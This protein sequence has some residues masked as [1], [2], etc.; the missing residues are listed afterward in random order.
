MA[1]YKTHVTV[2]AVVSSA[3]ALLLLVKGHATVVGACIFAGVGTVGS[4]LPDIDL[5][6]STPSK[7][8]FYLFGG[9]AALIA[10][11]SAMQNQLLLHETIV[12]A[13]GG[14]LL[15]RFGAREFFYQ[16]CDH[17]G[18]M[19]S[20]IVAVISAEI[21]AIVAM[22][23]FMFSRTNSLIMAG[24]MFG[25]FLL[26]LL[27]DEIY[28]VDFEN[29]RIKRSFGTALKLVSDNRLINMVLMICL[30][31]LLPMVVDSDIFVWQLVPD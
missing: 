20:V 21:T 24:F 14:F 17:R 1:N 23:G 26:H 30:L 5:H 7:K 11:M 8:L 9:I 28:S 2:G 25:G 12:S 6:Y 10:S 22:H 16:A 29:R 15:V 13:A 31:L 18:A 4:I 27:L 3:V 19:H